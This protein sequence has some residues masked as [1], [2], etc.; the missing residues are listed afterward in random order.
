M[1]RREAQTTKSDFP[2]FLFENNHLEVPKFVQD[3]IKSCS[4]NPNIR[5]P[6]DSVAC[7]T[8]K[9]AFPPTT[10]NTDATSPSVFETSE[11]SE[12]PRS[13]TNC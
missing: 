7:I 5:N 12:A 13:V 4:T 6:Y 9:L 3:N 1:L 10:T 8:T 11:A 2:D